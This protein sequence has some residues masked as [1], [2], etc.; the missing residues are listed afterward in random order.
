M[1]ELKK[2]VD[3]NRYKKP[4]STPQRAMTISFIKCNP[5]EWNYI[6]TMAQI[7]GLSLSDYIRKRA[8]QPK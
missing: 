1:E 6:R 5:L 7:E 3:L 4:K 2:V 8:M